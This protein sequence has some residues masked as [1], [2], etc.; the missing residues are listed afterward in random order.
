MTAPPPAI[1]EPGRIAALDGGYHCFVAPG[2]QAALALVYLAYCRAG[3]HV[4]IPE[5]AYGPTAE[6]G[7][8][9]LAG[10]GIEVER[11]DPLI[12]DGI[13]ALIRPYRVDLGELLP[14]LA[15]GMAAVLLIFPGKN[16]KL[17][18]WRGFV[19]LLVYAGFLFVST[20][21]Q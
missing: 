20:H 21:S 14:S 17:R 11:Y 9:L 8:D 12:A 15:F 19:L 3:S 13:A 10:F 2:G 18:G 1:A 5:S 7:E 16:G 6:L 4:L